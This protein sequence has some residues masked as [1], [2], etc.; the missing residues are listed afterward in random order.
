MGGG[1]CGVG[2]CHVRYG[3]TIERP[4]A[5]VGLLVASSDQ[6]E[7]AREVQT[8][9]A[10]FTLVLASGYRGDSLTY[11]VCCGRCTCRR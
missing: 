2:R 10:V 5:D 3:L 7:V 4:D 6:H 8:V 1:V 9:D 11:R